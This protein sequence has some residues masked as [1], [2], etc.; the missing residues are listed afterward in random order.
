M[1]AR[2]CT[3]IEEGREEEKGKEAPVECVWVATHGPLIAH[4]PFM[5]SRIRERKSP[6][7]CSFVYTA[8]AVRY[9]GATVCRYARCLIC[10]ERAYFRISDPDPALEISRGPPGRDVRSWP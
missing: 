1:R 9:V 10:T 4:G 6:S 3:P 7:V 5:D 2:A 8:A